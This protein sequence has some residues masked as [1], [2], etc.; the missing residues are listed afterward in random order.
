MKIILLII[1]GKIGIFLQSSWF[2][3]KC[4]IYLG[5]IVVYKWRIEYIL[6]LF[7]YL[8]FVSGDYF[9]MFR[10]MI[11]KNVFK[12]G[13]ILFL[14]I[15]YEKFVIKGEFYVFYRKNEIIM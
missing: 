4:L 3:L 12:L 8:I 11:E 13:I 10:N 6:G 9:L 1:V 7:V 15:E 5:D 14:F 2:E